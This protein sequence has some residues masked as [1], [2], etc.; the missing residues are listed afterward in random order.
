ME[1]FNTTATLTE[2]F[3]DEQ[4][5]INELSQ[6]TST[7]FNSSFNFESNTTIPSSQFQVSAITTT[8]KPG[9]SIRKR[10]W[11]NLAAP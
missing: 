4:D 5:L 9:L 8:V 6:L 1:D 3:D 10:I 11:L 7:T 2:L